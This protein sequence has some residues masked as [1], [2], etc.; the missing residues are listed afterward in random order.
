MAQELGDGEFWLPPQFLTDDDILM[1]FKQPCKA[2]G[3]GGDGFGPNSD[4]SS[5]V[6]SVMG[7]TET[8]SDEEDFLVGLTWKM[9]NSTLTDDMWKV[10]NTKTWGMATSPQSTLC[11][12][13]GT[14]RCKQG[15][16][17][18]S[19]NCP[20]PPAATAFNQNVAAWDLL[21]A[22]AGE[23]ARMK[24]A[25]QAPGSGFSSSRGFLAPSR[26]PSPISV[27]HKN[28][29]SNLGFNSNHQSLSYHQ[30]QAVQFQQM[31]QQQMLKQ[32]HQHQHQYQQNHHQP[33]V[34]NRVRNGPNSRPLGLS[35]SAWPTL[36]QS[37]QPQGQGQQAQS[38]PQ[39][40][41][42]GSGM[43]AVFLGNPGAKR[44]CTGTG[45]FLP[46]Q[47]GTQTDSRKKRGGCSTVLLPD[48][49]VQALNLNLD[50]MDVP[51]QPQP[52]TLALD[53]EA[54]LRYRS[55]LMTQQQW[56]NA[57]HARQPV[58]IE[59][60]LRLPQEWTY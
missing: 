20:S 12:V 26:K 57:R 21:S 5:P 38:Q 13:M 54:D 55:V 2:N 47:I 35:M 56:R 19:P 15:S 23:V 42:P 25:E 17:R 40:H 50:A 27:P 6:E 45:V 58:V 8:E 39:S 18:G 1:D 43:R 4:L 9:V 33:M 16:S 3:D 53:Y 37:H 34:H 41:P 28:Q 46:R 22:A 36:Q 48:R 59:N 32:Q 7:S 49:V 29:N 52:R 51:P 11:N 30:L 31:K 10:D 14:C 24:M 60:E 44:E